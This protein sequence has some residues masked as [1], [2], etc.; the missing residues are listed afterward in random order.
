MS[1]MS[2]RLAVWLAMRATGATYQEAVK[3]IDIFREPA[4][5]IIRLMRE[6]TEAMIERTAIQGESP[7][8]TAGGSRARI[9]H[10]WRL[11]IDEA[12]K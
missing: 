6:P 8:I 12:L 2:D 4:R 7:V 10:Y 3:S 11:M 5:D 1:E 9:P